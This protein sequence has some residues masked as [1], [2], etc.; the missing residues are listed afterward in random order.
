MYQK[1]RFILVSYDEGI[2]SILVSTSLELSALQIIEL[3]SYRFKIEVGFKELKH[4]IWAFAYHFWSKYM[5]KLS[6][7]DN[8]INALAL[9]SIADDHAKEKIVEA[10]KAIEGYVLM[11][12][13][14]MGLLQ[15][16]S[17]KYSCSVLIL[18]AI[19]LAICATS[20]E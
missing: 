19:V 14:S 18:M 7:W 10:L 4:T 12:I 16:F 20:N 6:R 1:L 15:I 3:Y 11:A 5:P 17:L 8:E 9:E 2:Q 13:I